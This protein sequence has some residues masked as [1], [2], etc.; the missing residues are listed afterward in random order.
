[1]AES[2][3]KK[4]TLPIA[5]IWAMVRD[6]IWWYVFSILFFLA[7]AVFYLYRTPNTYSRV[8]KVIVDEDSQSSMG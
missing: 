1:M 5:D 4:T 7:V 6:N 3:E 8:E 2:I